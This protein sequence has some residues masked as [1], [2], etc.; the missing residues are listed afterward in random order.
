MK[1]DAIVRA[2]DHSTET[3]FESWLRGVAAWMEQGM[4]AAPFQTG[5][6]QPQGLFLVQ[7]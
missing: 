6:R 2:Q 4:E 1:V 5:G 7:F 3:R